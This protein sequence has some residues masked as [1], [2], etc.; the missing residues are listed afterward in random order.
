MFQFYPLS[1]HWYGMPLVYMMWEASVDLARYECE[2]L[3]GN[4]F[5]RLDPLL[6]RP[7]DIDEVRQMGYLHKV[8]MSINLDKEKEWLDQHFLN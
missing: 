5:L 6:K 1:R 3:L 2:Q 7:V 8:A 4:R